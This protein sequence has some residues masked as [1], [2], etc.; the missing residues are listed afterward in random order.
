ML[1]V[2]QILTGSVSSNAFVPTKNLKN[3]F[4]V[5]KEFVVRCG[6]AKLCS[7]KQSSVGESM[8]MYSGKLLVVYVPTS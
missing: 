5:L 2:M 6:S 1:L 4:A 7:I 8:I 3:K